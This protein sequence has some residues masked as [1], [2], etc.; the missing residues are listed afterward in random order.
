MATLLGLTS[1]S[2][3]RCVDLTPASVVHRSI[4][5]SCAR[6]IFREAQAANSDSRNCGLLAPSS[7]ITSAGKPAHAPATVNPLSFSLRSSRPHVQSNSKAV[8]LSRLHT[9]H[10]AHCRLTT[11]RCS[12]AGDALLYSAAALSC[13]VQVLYAV[14]QQ[15]ILEDYHAVAHGHSIVR[16]TPISCECLLFCWCDSSPAGTT[17]SAFLYETLPQCAGPNRAAAG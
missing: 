14:E 10:T 8:R 3:C 6:A 9:L 4:D 2:Q 16:G 11:I 17:G 1:P 15:R 13:T 7:A 12:L 5:H